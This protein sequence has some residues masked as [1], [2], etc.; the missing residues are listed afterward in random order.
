MFFKFNDGFTQIDFTGSKRLLTFFGFG[1]FIDDVGWTI[2]LSMSNLE[3]Y[4]PF[5]I[6][7]PSYLW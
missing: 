4:C 1:F 6:F 3:D 2:S 5:Q 7:A